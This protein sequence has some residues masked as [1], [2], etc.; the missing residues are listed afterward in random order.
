MDED[1]AWTVNTW[2]ST[3]GVPELRE[4]GD[5]IV[6]HGQLRLFEDGGAVL[7][8]GGALILFDGADSPLP[9]GVDGSWVKVRAAR[10]RVSVWPCGV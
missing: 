6:F 7:D 10:D 2:R 3:S 4:D 1:I 9:E 8:V 5:H